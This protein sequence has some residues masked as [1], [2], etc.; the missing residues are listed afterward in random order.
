MVM[1]SLSIWKIG[2]FAL[3]YEHVNIGTSQPYLENELKVYLNLLSYK[4]SQL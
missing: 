4:V 3:K 1:Q 2:C